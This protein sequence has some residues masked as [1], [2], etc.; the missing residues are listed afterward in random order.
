VE[1]EQ[2]A[3][4]FKDKNYDFDLR[5]ESKKSKLRIGTHPGQS[6]SVNQVESNTPGLIAQMKGSS[7]TTR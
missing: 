1:V 5:K 2:E 4:I 3:K 6:V 7:T